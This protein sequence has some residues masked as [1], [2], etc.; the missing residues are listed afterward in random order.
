M[1]SV[2]GNGTDIAGMGV[3]SSTVSVNGGEAPNTSSGVNLALILG[4]C[5]PVGVILIGILVY[6]LCIRKKSPYPPV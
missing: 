3:I 1:N 6:F 2:L 5:I 4:I